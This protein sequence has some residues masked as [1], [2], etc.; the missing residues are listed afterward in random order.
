MKK[1]IACLL[2]GAALVGCRKEEVGVTEGPN[3]VDVYGTFEIV[4]GLAAS[5]TAVDFSN[6][7]TVYFTAEITKITD[8]K[9]TITGQTSGAE[10]V[11]EG[12]SNKLDASNATWNGSTTSFP[13]F[14]AETCDVILT[15]DGETDTLTT[16]VTVASPKT[17]IGFILAD[18][19]TG[20]LSG[21]SNFIQ[22]GGNMDFNIKT[23]ASS[24]QEGAY[25]NMQGLVDWD[26]LIGLLDFNA[27][28]YGATTLPLTANSDILY[29][30]ALVYGEAGLPNSLVLFRFDE[31]E[32][33]DG[34]FD[35]AS[36]DQYQKEIPIDWEGW[37][38]ISIP[39]NELDGGG[40]GNGAYNPDKLNKVSVL[41]LANPASGFAKSGLD[42]MIFT[43]NGPLQP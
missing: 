20:Y 36:E 18:F 26:W 3:L 31:D 10:K 29:F 13:M 17:N 34:T 2:I 15:F 28:A 12:I 32:N 19:E 35:P 4:T 1:V 9:I 33:E 8:W 7:E 37:K 30:N 16:T 40:T 43:E 23:D 39:Y 11:I 24:P 25:I 42:Y 5:Q 6:G 22:S 27:S 41:H 14:R 38:L 21:W